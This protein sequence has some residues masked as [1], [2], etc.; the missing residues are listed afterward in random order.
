MEY[1]ILA[2]YFIGNLEIHVNE[3]ISAGWSPLG[4]VSVS[5][6]KDRDGDDAYEFYQAMIRARKEAS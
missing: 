5:R 3:A 4:G 2:Y 6:T 1:R